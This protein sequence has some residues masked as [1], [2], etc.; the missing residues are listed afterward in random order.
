MHT[1]LAVFAGK[2]FWRDQKKTN[3]KNKNLEESPGTT[4][5]ACLVF[6][7]KLVLVKTKIHWQF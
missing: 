4:L 6:L 5:F 2:L 1:H 7:R 3:L